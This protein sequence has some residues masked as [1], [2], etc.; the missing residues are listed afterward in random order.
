M[1]VLLLTVIVLIYLFI[2]GYLAFAA[3]RKTKST[4]DYLIAGRNIHPYIMAISYG[5]T[6]ISTSAIIGFGGAAAIFG[7]GILWL[8]FLNIFV[9]IF[10]AFVFFGRR[11]RVMGL[12]LNAHTFPEFLGNRFQSPFLQGMTGL[13]IFIAM[14][15][16]AAVVLMGGSQFIAQVLGINY[17][18][19]T[20]E[21]MG[22]DLLGNMTVHTNSEGSVT[23]FD[24]L[25][26][27]RLTSVIH[28]GWDGLTLTNRFIYDNQF[29]SLNIID[30]LGRNVESYSL[31][32][33]DRPTS[34]TNV[35]NQT[36]SITYGLGQMIKQVTRFDGTTVSNAYDSSARL[37]AV[38]Y[39]DK[40][41][42]FGY[43]K[44]GLLKFVANGSAV[45]S[46]TYDKAN[47]LTASITFR[48]EPDEL[49]LEYSLDSVGNPTNI[50][51]SVDDSAILTNSFAFDV[52]ERLSTQNTEAGQFVY[53][54]NSYNG[55]ISSVSNVASGIKVSYVYN[56]MDR[57]TDIIWKNA[58]EQTLKS[59]DYAY[60]PAGMITNVIHENG[61]GSLYTFDSLHRLVD[62]TQTDNTG[63]VTRTEDIQYDAAGNRT[64]KTRD[65]VSVNY[66]LATGNRLASW[67]ISGS[68]PSFIEDISGHSSETIGTGEQF[69]QLWV[70]NTTAVTPE[71]SGTNFSLNAMTIG[72]GTQEITAAICDVAGNT[73]YITNTI[74]SRVVTNAAYSYNTAGCVTGIT[75]NG[76]AYPEKTIGL[77]W[78][79]QYQ[80]TAASTNGTVA[81][82]YIY[83]AY[84]RRVTTIFGAGL[85]S[86]RINNHVYNGIHCIADLDSNGYLIRSYTIGTGI[87][88]WLSMTVHTGATAVTYYYL[89]DHLGTVHALADENGDIVESYKYD[90]WGRVLGVYDGDDVPLE[91][92]AVGNRILWQG[93]EYSWTTDLYYFRARTYDPVTTRWLSKDP[94]GISGGL[95]QYVFCGNNPVNFRDPSGLCPE[96]MP[97]WETISSGYD[98]SWNNLSTSHDM[99]LFSVAGG[100]VNGRPVL[101]R[102]QAQNLAHVAEGTFHVSSQSLMNYW[103]LSSAFAMPASASTITVSRWQTPPS[104]AL[105]SGNWVVRG[106]RTRWNWAMSGKMN[107]LR[108]RYHVPFKHGRTFRIPQSSFR[109]PTGVEGF[110]AL[111]PWRQGRFYP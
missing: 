39:P 105:R 14:P 17:P 101:T 62:E 27:R 19:N 106:G 30:A 110:K 28:N 40:T 93:R 31:D 18:N 74:I 54:Y 99:Y 42:N 3:Y 95:N 104:D 20:S 12:N 81:E 2:I 22:Y 6:F 58:S 59:F 13:L 80:L 85:P 109:P 34:V 33:Q 16:Y 63:A 5:A 9:G 46:N 89:T 71:I 41:L 56:T 88:N 65:S 98:N 45:I 83:D 1:N 37:N 47:R 57:V 97:Q 21:S 67:N 87:D 26:T 48:D 43:Y 111:P 53:S 77:T 61:S 7:M 38:H 75:Y 44:N 8:T 10:I 107:P 82:T 29:N 91:E 69:G 68:A 4:S 72:S 23:A 94:I 49:N 76:I 70:S 11:T 32:M 15:L 73:A 52:A 50:L 66:T 55:L 92:S 60:S 103:A 90:A 96:D 108:S 100:G 79:S 35:E 36:M 78:N 64:S 86:A 24:H 51:V 84:G 25:P 102:N